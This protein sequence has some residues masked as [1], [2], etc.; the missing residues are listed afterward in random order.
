MDVMVNCMDKITVK[1]VT[2]HFYVLKKNRY[3]YIF[4]IDFGTSENKSIFSACVSI[5]YT[6]HF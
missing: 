2:F 5:H 6:T 1:Y 3:N 4:Q